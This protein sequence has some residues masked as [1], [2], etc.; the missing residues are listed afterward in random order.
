MWGFIL[1]ENKIT[2]LSKAAGSNLSPGALEGW[3]MTQETEGEKY[4]WIVRGGG[5]QRN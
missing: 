2:L 1:S 3:S 5:G 4:I